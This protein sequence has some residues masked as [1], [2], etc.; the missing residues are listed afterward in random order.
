MVYH[1]HYDFSNPY[2]IYIS[3]AI[4]KGFDAS[5]G[6]NLTYFYASLGTNLMYFDASLGTNLTYFI[7]AI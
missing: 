7:F 3:D 6:T 2:R 4:L 5:L 1:L